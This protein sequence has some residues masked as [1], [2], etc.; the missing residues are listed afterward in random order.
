MEATTKKVRVK[1]MSPNVLYC[2]VRET[3]RGRWKR[4]TFYTLGWPDILAVTES[5]FQTDDPVYAAFVKE[6]RVVALFSTSLEHLETLLLMPGLF[7]WRK[8]IVFADVPQK[9][10]PVILSVSKAKGG[11]L[12]FNEFKVLEAK[13]G[14]VTAQPVPENYKMRALDPET[15]TD[16]AVSTRPYY[17]KGARCYVRDLL[18]KFPS[19]GV[20]DKDDICIGFEIIYHYGTQG[21]LHVRE[22]FRGQGIGTSIATNLAQKFFSDGLPVYT[23]VE[24]SNSSSIHLHLKVGFRIVADVDYLRYHYAGVKTELSENT[25]CPE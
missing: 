22:E 6:T 2:T 8:R 13:P 16:Y 11:T 20:F 5:P 7:N 12:G 25:V 19:I 15:H 17:I 4:C 10:R 23:V 3:I 24:K 21:M 14:E 9:L 18:K 1:L